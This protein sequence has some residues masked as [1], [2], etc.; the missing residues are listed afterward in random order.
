[1]DDLEVGQWYVAEVP[2][3]ESRKYTGK[4]VRIIRGADGVDVFM[5]QGRTAFSV[6][7]DELV[8]IHPTEPPT[9]GVKR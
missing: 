1:M 3:R 5:F 4:L 7:S 8:G 9:T 2:V 6:A